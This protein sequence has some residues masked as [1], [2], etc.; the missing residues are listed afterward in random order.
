M[1]L[2]TSD[3]FGLAKNVVSPRTW[4]LLEFSQYIRKVKP[5]WQPAVHYRRQ[6]RNLKISLCETERWY[7]RGF[8]MLMNR[9]CQVNDKRLLEFK[10]RRR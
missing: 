6:F 1:Q 9:V 2:L 8:A 7:E 10:V 5:V 4:Q 3:R